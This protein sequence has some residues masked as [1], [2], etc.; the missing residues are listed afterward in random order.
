M[1]YKI[2]F[3]FHM[4]DASYFCLTIK[5]LC[6]IDWNKCHSFEHIVETRRF[7]VTGLDLLGFVIE[8]SI[9]KWCVHLQFSDTFTT[10]S[11]I[12]AGGAWTMEKCVLQILFK[13][14]GFGMV[15]RIIVNGFHAMPF[16]Q[17]LNIATLYLRLKLGYVHLYPFSLM[18]L[19][20]VI[21]C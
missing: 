20:L 5:N 17:S 18:S 6:I 4:P 10:N 12:I 14:Q 2:V 9:L 7:Y 19:G 3:G 16:I 13:H 1:V 21:T 8:D 15:V 11:C